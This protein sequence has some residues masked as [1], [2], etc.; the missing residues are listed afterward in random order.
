MNND[1]LI[2]YGVLGMR[3][4][5]RRRSV[6][7]PSKSSSGSSK[8]Q[9]RRMSN[10]ELT[11]RVKRLKLEQEYI[12]LTTPEQKATKSKIEKFVSTMDTVAKL[13]GTANTIYKNLNDMGVLDRRRS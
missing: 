4:G 12:K 5:V 2:H 8:N 9:N 11:A 7:V 10:K 1:C 6:V 3:W 13:S